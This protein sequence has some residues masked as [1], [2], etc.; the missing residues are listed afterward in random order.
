MYVDYCRRWAQEGR[1]FPVTDSLR[2]WGML[3]NAGG[4][5]CDAV[6]LLFR[7]ASSAAAKKGQRIERYYRDAAMYRS[8]IS[9]QF[10][11]LATG[12]GRLQF[13]LPMGMYG[14]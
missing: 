12:L 13:G 2:L 6:D 4:L 5:A 1:P 3:L 14:I 8:H 7:A 9:S 10:P 11:N